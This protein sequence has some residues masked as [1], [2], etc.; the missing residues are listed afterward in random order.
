[1]FKPSSLLAFVALSCSIY[2][3]T[4]LAN[5]R[6]LVYTAVAPD[7]YY[8][9]SIPDAVAAMKK[10][11]EENEIDMIHCDDR[12]EFAKLNL[13]QF[14]ALAFVSAAGSIL[15]TDG[16]ANMREYIENGG[17]YV[18]I[19]EASCAATAVPWYLRLVG[20]QFNYHPEL[21]RATINVLDE[22][23]PSTR[24]LGP[25]WEVYDEIYNFL[26]DPRDLGATVLLSPNQSTYWDEIQSL[27]ERNKIQGSPHPIAWYREGNL[28]THPSHTTL[29]GGLDNTKAAIRK[30]TQGSGGDGRS[31][32][33]SLGHTHACWSQ[34]DFLQHVL[35]G[36]QWVLASD[37]IASNQ[38]S[39]SKHAV[40]QAYNGTTPAKTAMT[41]P[42][43]SSSSDASTATASSS[44]MASGG[45]N[46]NAKTTSGAASASVTLATAFTMAAAT[47]VLGSIAIIA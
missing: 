41:A 14:D 26:S 2:I 8:H 10:L 32:Y 39:P 44:S 5:Q 37:S 31:W 29:G 21:C 33:T 43:S 12:D 3:G 23:H 9:P 15:T 47:L 38:A 4:A 35:G 6:V 19:H 7:G 27:E 28:L 20:S 30:G 42:V 36:V 13:T 34:D 45:K 40:G 22:S 25:T 17:G 16:E 18:G 24:H 1:M 46:S 11:G